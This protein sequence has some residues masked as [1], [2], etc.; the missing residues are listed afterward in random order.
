MVV[1]DLSNEVFIPLVSGIVPEIRNNARHGRYSY[2]QFN[3]IV[4]LIPD[5]T[6]RKSQ[7]KKDRTPRSG[8]NTG[9]TIVNLDETIVNKD[10]FNLKHR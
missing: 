3:V 5:R 4:N 10:F 9:L 1:K 6:A 8:P 2:W 7:K